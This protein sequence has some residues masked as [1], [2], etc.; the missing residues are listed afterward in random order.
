[1]A[2]ISFGGH[3]WKY[4]CRH[5]EDRSVTAEK[6]LRRDLLS[7]NTD[8]PNWSQGS[9]CRGVQVT[10]TNECLTVSPENK[11][12]MPHIARM[13]RQECSRR[14]PIRTFGWLLEKWFSHEKCLSAGSR[15]STTNF[16]RRN[17]ALP[18]IFF[19][20]LNESKLVKYPGELSKY[21]VTDASSGKYDLYIF[22][23]G[24]PAQAQGWSQ[25][26]PDAFCFGL[27]C[28]SFTSRSFVHSG[29]SKYRS[30]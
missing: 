22:Q 8:S 28:L 15:N 6:L 16:R 17:L 27:Q 25:R 13:E 2:G 1:M 23:V 4:L 12:E 30:T 5:Q 14:V 21:L 24:N 11:Q 18:Y 19:I 10:G 9:G 3:H 26:I 29:L 7:K 20:K